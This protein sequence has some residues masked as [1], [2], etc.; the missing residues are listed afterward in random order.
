MGLRSDQMFFCRLG[1]L[2][3]T[4]LQLIICDCQGSELGSC[5]KVEVA[6]LGSPSLISL[7]VSTLKHTT[8]VSIY[9]GSPFKTRT[10]IRWIPEEGEK[11]K[12]VAQKKIAQISRGGAEESWPHLGHHG[13]NGQV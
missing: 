12:A 7:M 3:K 5:V 10:V 13:E 2:F 8:D 11:E 1:S 4:L 9:S 6:V